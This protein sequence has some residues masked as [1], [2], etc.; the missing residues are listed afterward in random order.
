MEA[1]AGQSRAWAFL[2]HGRKS[3]GEN[4]MLV[5]G[6]GLHSLCSLGKDFFPLR[7]RGAPRAF[8]AQPLVPLGCTSL[9]KDLFHWGN[10]Q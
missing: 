10:F 7:T 4:G 8:A 5:C 9:G 2:A 6:T 1:A 3:L